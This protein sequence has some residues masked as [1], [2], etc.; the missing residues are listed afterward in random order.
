MKSGSSLIY[1]RCS[2]WD[3]NI[4]S[5]SSMPLH[6]E[7]LRPASQVPAEFIDLSSHIHRESSALAGLRVNLGQD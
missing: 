6:T 4:L 7:L 3:L 5:N 1:L 2:H